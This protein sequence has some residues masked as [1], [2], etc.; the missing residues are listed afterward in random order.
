MDDITRWLEAQRKAE[1]LRPATFAR[2]LGISPSMYAA[3]LNDERQPGRVVRDAVARAYP[4]APAA[5]FLP[6]GL[7]TDE[8]RKRMG[9]P[10]ADQRKDE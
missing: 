6:S 9:R 2:K 1:R 5:L 3:M 10:R 8:S 4:H 7:H